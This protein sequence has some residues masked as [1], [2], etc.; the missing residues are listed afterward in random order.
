MLTK[1]APAQD[2]EI[3]AQA[4]AAAVAPAGPSMEDQIV[5]AGNEEPPVEPP[6]E[7]EAQGE[8]EPPVEPPAP[9][10]PAEEAEGTVLEYPFGSL[11]KTKTGWEARID[12][13][14]GSGVQRYI[15]RTKDELLGKLIQAQANASKKIRQQE[16]D[17]LRA[18][19][20]E[21][22]DPASTRRRLAPRA[23]SADEQYEFA[24][25]IASGDPT[26]INKAMQKRDS[27]VLGGPVEEV[28][29]QV[30]EVKDQLEY[31]SYTAT[32]KSFIKQNPD[33]QF[34]K[35]IGDKIDAVLNENQWGYTI[36]NLNK[37]LQML[38]DA[39]EIQRISTPEEVELPEPTVHRTAAAVEAAAPAV[40][41]AAAQAAPAAQRPA[42]PAVGKKT[43]QRLRPGS[44]S[45]GISPRQASVRAGVNATPAPAVGLT[46]E[47]YNRLPVSETKRR[48]KTD[49]GFRSAVDK[50]IADGKI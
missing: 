44:A 8:P 14:D 26:R 17:R 19:A 34:T 35:E 24:E 40:P 46:A 31:D 50:L 6:A 39:G 1:Q 7:P 37:A 45:T 2:T 22:A 18:L 42:T 5:N 15:A 20:D 4:Q 12:N 43:E 48:Y 32:A 9:T 29:G 13:N 30:N 16:A 28:I 21:P 38:V 47:E 23:M 41:A 10:A 11:V 49:L 3:P 27:I 36:R 33:V 25:A